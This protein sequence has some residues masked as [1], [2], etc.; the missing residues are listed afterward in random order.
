MY[1]KFPSL[2]ER[3]EKK[4]ILQQSRLLHRDVVTPVLQR[5]VVHGD[6]LLLRGNAELGELR[7]EHRTHAG[8]LA[9]GETRLGVL[10]ES[11]DG[12]AHRVVELVHGGVTRRLRQ[13]RHGVDHALAVGAVDLLTLGGDVQATALRLVEV[14]VRE[15]EQLDAVFRDDLSREVGED[16]VGLCRLGGDVSRRDDEVEGAVR[17]SDGEV[18]HLSRSL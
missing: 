12:R 3:L 13:E 2:R 16:A 8:G 4:K 1:S 9:A 5:E 14:Q 17:E 7:L 6:R 18:V 10:D 15:R 11:Q